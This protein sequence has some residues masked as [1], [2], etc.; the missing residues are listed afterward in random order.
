MK[1]KVKSIAKQ[2][3]ESECHWEAWILLNSGI[4]EKTF[5]PYDNLCE[6]AVQNYNLNE[7]RRQQDFKDQLH[8]F[9]IWW[10]KHKV[11]MRKYKS[12]SAIGGLVDKDHGTIIHYIGTKN[13]PGARKPSSNFE[14]N[15]ECIKDFLES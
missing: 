3:K 1:K 5:T 14:K 8:Y 6:L 10:E 2:V 11:L 13:K 12:K 4:D 9:L 15:V 7:R